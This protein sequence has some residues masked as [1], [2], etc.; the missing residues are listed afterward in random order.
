MMLG[1]YR[2]PRDVDPEKY[3]IEPIE[4]AK[5]GGRGPDGRIWHW[6]IGGGLK[7][8]LHMIDFSRQGP[9]EGEPL[10]EKVYEVRKDD[11][12]TA[13]I[14]LVASGNRKRWIVASAN[15]KPGDLIKTSG[16]LTSMPVRAEE[17][18]AHPMGSLPLGTVVH[19]LE[20]LPGEGATVAR[21]AGCS[22]MYLRK[23]GDKCVVR[24]P[25]KRELI[26]TPECM[27][28]VGQAS[29]PDWHRDKKM[30][31]PEE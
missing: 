14:A 8:K 16:K 20:R 7:K 31:G 19:C 18:D 30:S 6:K 11:W 17:G 3:T 27:V 21:S 28:T 24:M 25:S 15:M 10:V 23:V 2:L 9:K 29:N 22:G 13:H 26:L 4:T 12:R 1:K 5:T